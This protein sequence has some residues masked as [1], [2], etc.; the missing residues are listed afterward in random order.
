MYIFPSSCLIKADFIDTSKGGKKMKRKALYASGL[1]LFTILASAGLVSAF[2]SGML[3]EDQNSEIIQAV[4]ENDFAAWKAA[5]EE[6]LTQENFDR[7]VERHKDMTERKGMQDALRQAVANGDYDAYKQ[8]FE[9][10]KGSMEMMSEEEFNAMVERY[11][12]GGF[13][14]GMGRGRGVGIGVAW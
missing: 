11:Q 13:G 7:L 1:M 5:V 9:N 2:G 10:L 4:E 6:T 3:S 14:G 8:A 12:E